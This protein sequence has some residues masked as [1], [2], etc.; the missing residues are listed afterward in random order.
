MVWRGAQCIVRAG[1]NA[2]T[3]MRHDRN[4]IAIAIVIKLPKHLIEGAAGVT[5]AQ[6]DQ[7]VGEIQFLVVVAVGSETH[8]RIEF[9]ADKPPLFDGV[10][11][12][13]KR[14]LFG[15]PLSWSIMPGV[16]SDEAMDGS[17]SPSNQGDLLQQHSLLIG[18]S[19]LVLVH[20]PFL[21]RPRSEIDDRRRH[22]A[23]FVGYV[24]TKFP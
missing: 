18:R 19:C 23:Q 24:F 6:F 4:F 5:F 8:R 21:S 7:L 13:L 17:T 16:E 3:A 1:P 15:L 22:E 9:H 11:N 10:A 2:V 12:D 14:F 20:I